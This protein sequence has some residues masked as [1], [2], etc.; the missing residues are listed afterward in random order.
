M[1][2][3][4]NLIAAASKGYPDDMVSRWTAGMD[5]AIVLLPY[6]KK[7]SLTI[8][9]SLARFVASE[10]IGTYEADKDDGT[11]VEVALGA[12]SRAM[13]DIRDAYDAISKLDPVVSR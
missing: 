10:I 5:D 11:K 3:L 4:E 9:D 2:T 12:L 8:G 1:I 13:D 7:T 6:T